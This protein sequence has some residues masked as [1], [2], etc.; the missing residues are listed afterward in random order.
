M[1]R[2]INKHPLAIR[3]F[4]WINFPLL[5]IMIWSGL[6]IY[7]AYDPYAIKLFGVT[8]FKFF[9][10]WFYHK[11][12]IVHRLSEGMAFHFL[13]MWLFALN[14]LIYVLYTFISGEWRY[15]LPEKK[16]WREA[17]LVVLHD[18]HIRKSAPEQLKYNAA[19]RIA[20]TGII[21]MGIG[22]LITGLSIYK[23][24]QFNWL[25]FLCGGYHTARLIHFT[26]TIGYCL[27][28]VLHILQ[29]IIA[30]WNNFRA[31]V[32]GF[33][34]KAEKPAKPQMPHAPITPIKDVK[35]K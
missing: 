15:L 24:A 22:S 13:F 29:V 1:K 32:T 33:E 26:L 35:A 25:V 30:G 8:A 6:L 5:A 7:W 11:L 14:G 17:W 19:Q 31:I 9:P 12:N 10:E 28:F 16:S 21:I 20:Y 27:F 2:I 3:W 4:H 23:P 18:L 34:I